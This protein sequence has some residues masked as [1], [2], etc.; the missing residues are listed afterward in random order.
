MAQLH[1]IYLSPV[2]SHS[3]TFG[4][5]GGQIIPAFIGVEILLMDHRVFSKSS[6]MLQR[7]SYGVIV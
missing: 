1:N 4:K 5:P 6:Q 3:F 7:V 2:A